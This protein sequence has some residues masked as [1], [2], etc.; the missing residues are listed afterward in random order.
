[1]SSK[2]LGSLKCRASLLWGG[3]ALFAFSCAPNKNSGPASGESRVSIRINKDKLRQESGLSQGGAEVSLPDEF[4]YAVHVTGAG[5]EKTSAADLSCG[6]S[7]GLGL[8]T[9]KAYNRGDNAEVDVKV[10]TARR[11]ELFGFA[12][13]LGLENGRAK[14]G[15]LTV[16]LVK[17]DV[18]LTT[19]LKISVGGAEVTSKPILFA[20]GTADIVPG[21]NNITLEA[22]PKVVTSLTSQL[23]FGAPYYRIDSLTPP[24]ECVVPKKTLSSN[25]IFVNTGM[26]IKA[27]QVSATSIRTL[28]FITSSP[29]IFVRPGAGS[30]K[31][32]ASGNSEVATG[33]AEVI[34]RRESLR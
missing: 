19:Y 18:P 11:F 20:S 30:S 7:T 32:S 10:G 14:C 9:T 28:Q 16:E 27:P 31:P 8:V 33:M 24:A 26:A 12:S 4:C 17:G 15:T 2:G 1:M 23:A 3:L 13:P 29:E 25:H 22:T 34:D 6:P 21:D 5:L